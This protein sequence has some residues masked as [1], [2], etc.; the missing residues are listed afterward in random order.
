MEYIAHIRGSDNKIQT[1]YEH[2]L[3]VADLAMKYTQKLGISSIS[4]L[5][6]V[7][8]DAGKLTSDFNNYILGKSKFK[9]GDIDHSFAGAKYI[10]EI[11]DIN[12]D[13]N[14]H[15]ASRFIART[16]ISHHGLHDWVNED[17]D[18][19][20]LIRISKNDRYEEIK[21]NL[22]NLFNESELFD[23]LN[24]ASDEYAVIRHKIKELC[25]TYENGKRAEIFAFYLGMLERFMQSVIIDADR[26]DT[27][28]FFSG[29]N[30]E[31]DY[32]S[33]HLWGIMHDKMEE[34]LK[35]FE[36]ET[37]KISLRRKSISSRCA[38]FANH[39][40]G[41]CRLIVPT[42]GGKTLSSLRFA[43][44]YCKNYDMDKIIY[45]APFMS[46]LE[47]NSDE[48]QSIAGDDYFLEHHSNILQE[49]DGKEELEEY[50]LRSEKWDSPVIATTMV[51]FFNSLFL[52]K[53]SSVRRMHRL[54][55]AVIIIDEVQSVPLK[56]VNLFN[57][58]VNFLTKICKSTVVLC[59]A[60]QPVFENGEYPLM[61]DEKRSMTGDYSK[62]FDIFKR[63]EII[64]CLKKEGYTYEDSA[65][66]CFKKFLENGNLLVVVNTK[67]SAKTLYELIK[68]K[69]ESCQNLQKAEIVHLSTNLCPQHRREIICR[70]KKLL[71]EKKRIICITTQL[72][73]AGVDISFS[74]VVRSLAGMD[75][76]AQAAG[77]CNRNG[78]VNRVCPVYIID[79]RDERLSNM[80]DVKSAQSISR[81]II[82]NENTTDLLAVDTMSRYFEKLYKDNKSILSYNFKESEISDTI[83]NLLSLNSLRKST[84]N[85]NNRFCSQAFKTA[86]ENFKF[87]NKA[88]ETIIVPY[89]EEA[90]ELILDL[91][92]DI[93]PLE[94]VDLMRKAQKYTVGIYENLKKKI[95]ESGGII[96]LRCG[97]VALNSEFYDDIIGVTAE[98]KKK[99]VLMN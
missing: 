40:V 94:A 10:C 49:I 91:N 26:T 45:V 60:T 2:C 52:D 92:S 18:D 8:H 28:G 27:C 39:R 55:N 93:T 82:N 71:K 88:T 44:E 96:Q 64:P 32:D 38:E 57:L 77:R 72:I 17:G 33:A 74:G 51:Q 86:G 87:I 85:R 56:C 15:N 50:E 75:N 58:A 84:N 14:I 76:A 36:S 54:S 89:N 29:R 25:D 13:K 59:S 61:L 4:K 70:I 73:E 42:G 30:V 97:A 46:I 12:E 35:G 90:K 1:V 20:F 67:A 37:D 7:L 5:Q 48:I 22:T 3:G 11:A 21:R 41:A 43:I 83:L 69:N 6:A 34:K 63:T 78:E 47:Q 9:R 66:F 79:I 99:E 24:K 81:L 53:N 16:I 19:C 23:L 65:E 31:E 98:G 62:D 68:A 95:S 80:E